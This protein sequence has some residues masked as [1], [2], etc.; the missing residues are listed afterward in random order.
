MAIDLNRL[1]DVVHKNQQSAQARP[2]DPAKQVVVDRA[3][4]IHMRNELRPGEQV[5][6]V[7]QDTF[8]GDVTA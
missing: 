8:A 3:G 7:Q 6:E 2:A 1:R 5:T 4:S